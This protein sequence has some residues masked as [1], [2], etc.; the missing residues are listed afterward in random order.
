MYGETCIETISAMDTSRDRWVTHRGAATP[1][2]CVMN[3][4]I[5][6]SRP[7]FQ[8]NSAQAALIRGGLGLSQVQTPE[9]RP[10]GTM[11]PDGGLGLCR[12]AWQWALA[13]DNTYSWRS[14]CFPQL[15][16]PGLLRSE[17]IDA[18]E[19]TEQGGKTVATVPSGALP[20]LPPCPNPKEV[21]T[22]RG[23]LERRNCLSVEDF[24]KGSLQE[25][26]QPFQFMFIV[27]CLY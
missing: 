18:R 8:P 16:T 17:R 5:A 25:Q 19:C 3:Y 7:R 10:S 9:A 1:I 2:L 11:C 14:R 22:R 24:L 4:W 27:T 15:A 20:W 21:V 23:C 6:V 26:Q 12:R 13:A